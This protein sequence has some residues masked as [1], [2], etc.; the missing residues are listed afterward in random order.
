MLD[1]T[2]KASGLLGK[3]VSKIQNGEDISSNTPELLTEIGSFVDELSKGVPGRPMPDLGKILGAP[4]RDMALDSTSVEPVRIPTPVSE[5]TEEELISFMPEADV[6]G[7]ILG[8]EPDTESSKQTHYLHVHFD[9]GSKM[10][11]IRAFM[12]VNKLNESGK[13][14]RTIPDNL[15]NNPDAANTIVDNGL[16]ISYTTDITQEQVISLLKGTLSVGAVSFV[17]KM[18]DKEKAPIPKATETLAPSAANTQTQNEIPA[19]DID[20]TQTPS[21]SMVQ[22]PNVTADP[23]PKAQE[24]RTVVSAMSKSQEKAESDTVRAKPKGMD[25]IN[26]D[27]NKLDSLLDLVGEIVIN[28]SMVTENPDLEGLELDNFNKAARQLSKLTDELQDTVM[29]VRLVPI[30]NTFQRMR[31]VIRDMT[32]QLGKDAELILLRE[33]TEV[34]KTILDSI[35]DPIM[36]LVRNALDH[37]IENK[38]ERLAA[39]K[40]ATGRIILSAQNMGS[41]IVISISDDGRGLNPDIILDSANRKG[42][43]KKDR[44][45]YSE[46][47][48]YNMLM[49]P[50]FSTRDKVTEYSGRG[51]GLDVVKTQIEKSGGTVTVESALGIGTNVF[52]KIPLTLAI[53]DCMEV[54]LG[55]DVYAIPVTN[56]RET[57]KASVGQLIEDPLGDEMILL[58]GTPYPIIR[59]H[60]AFGIE[61]AQTSIDRGI[62][63]LVTSGDLQGCFLADELVGKFQVVVKAI[64]EYLHSYKVKSTGISGCS[65]M[66]N[67]DI[68]LIIDAGELLHDSS[69]R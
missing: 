16:Y 10:E 27:I 49:L 17:S 13:V 44:E 57:F 41:D 30:S 18:P 1:L 62:L 3:E 56:I 58:R 54:R 36:H 23:E 38:S 63:V 34:D 21:S 25:L 61:N 33:N 31:R 19:P 2:L 26:V 37:G 46:K 60:E 14:N 32:R 48:I 45:E 4:P 51:V 55:S 59:L 42:L 29:S 47:E 53:I 11:N 66:G 22:S 9:D 20:T 67:G 12:L 8:I 35:G 24:D 52:L 5:P 6:G 65:I 50:G 28:E 68:C 15:E 39:G 64:P 40:S 69:N 7:R 43:L